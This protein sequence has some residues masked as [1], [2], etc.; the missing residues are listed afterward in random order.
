MT[1][2]D[3]FFG[4]PAPPAIWAFER[5]RITDNESANPGLGYTIAYS[6]PMVE[7]TLYIYDYALPNIA[8]GP[9]GD[10]VRGHF[11]EVTREILALPSVGHYAR[12]DLVDR[13]VTGTPGAGPEFL[14][15]VFLVNSGTNDFWSFLFLTGHSNKYVKWRISVHAEESAEVVARTLVDRHADL[16]WP[17]HAHLRL[18]S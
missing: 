5:G 16:I 13:Y 4:I 7:A 2:P 12:V 17:S 1:E 8:E 18:D 6:G 3:S 9:Y 11:D 15:A 10:E 14:A